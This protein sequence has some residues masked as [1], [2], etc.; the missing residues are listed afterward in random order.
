MKTKKM[1]M[2]AL[3]AALTLVAT[4]VITIPSSTGYIHM[5]DALVLLSAYILG[6]VNGALAAG[7]GSALADFISGYAIFAVPTLI[8]KALVAFVSGY[9]YLK[10]KTHPFWKLLLIGLIGESF[11][12][13]GYFVV[14]IFL[15]GSIATAAVGIYGSFVQA[16][17]GIAVSAIIYN[18]LKSNT[19]IKKYLE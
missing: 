10:A 15:S 4:L 18:L 2:S 19:V 16:I 9:L 5:G 17:L 14:E 11:M 7:L 6:P 12:I 13:V 3:F 1:I 8:I